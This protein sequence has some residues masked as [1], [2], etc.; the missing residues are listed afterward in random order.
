VL[1]LKAGTTT[2]RFSAEVFFYRNALW[3]PFILHSD[4]HYVVL[5]YCWC[6]WGSQSMI[7]LKPYV[8][9]EQRVW[10]SVCVATPCSKASLEGVGPGKHC[11]G[12]DSL[13]VR[14]GTE[15]P[16]FPCVCF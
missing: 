3:F 8:R 9:R 14:L 7:P 2:A 1:R 12:L 6:W 10:G 4:S 5:C 16:V 11:Q 13:G 15:Q